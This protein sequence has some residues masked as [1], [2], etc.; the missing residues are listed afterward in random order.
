MIFCL[1]FN[2]LLFNSVSVK[3]PS[4][5]VL[6][7]TIRY[8]FITG[9]F[10]HFTVFLFH[11]M[12]KVKKKKIIFLN[13]G[14]ILLLSLFRN[15]FSIYYILTCCKSRVVVIW[16]WGGVVAWWSRFDL[17]NSTTR[18][19]S[20]RIYVR[21]CQTHLCSANKVDTNIKFSLPQNKHETII[22]YYLYE[23]DATD[24]CI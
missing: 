2:Y 11:K 23:Q 4:D 14:M 22:W 12:T 15:F 5:L 18:Y 1:F 8:F 19:T 7:F 20:C 17:T 24:I 13:D 10:I 6:I 21:T 3:G 9:T 16:W